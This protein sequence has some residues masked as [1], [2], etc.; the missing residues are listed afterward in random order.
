[1]Y[2]NRSTNTD[3]NKIIQDYPLQLNRFKNIDNI[4]NSPKELLWN[5]RIN[6]TDFDIKN[7]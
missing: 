5:E 4:R 3:L 2:N 7:L 6:K 1:M